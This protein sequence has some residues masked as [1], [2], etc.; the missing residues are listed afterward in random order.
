MIFAYS[1]LSEA[2]LSFLGVGIP[3]EVPSWGNITILEKGYVKYE[4]PDI[5]Y[6]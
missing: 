2:S 6:I 5:L 1:I 4:D 3:P